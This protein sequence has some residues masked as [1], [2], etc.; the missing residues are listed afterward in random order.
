MEDKYINEVTDGVF[1]ALFFA[2]KELETISDEKNSLQIDILSA[3][4]DLEVINSLIKSKKSYIES[5]ESE[6][7]QVEDKNNKDILFVESEKLKLTNFIEEKN[8]TILQFNKAL[9]DRIA[10]VKHLDI[11]IARLS[12]VKKVLD[13]EIANSEKA[14]EKVLVN[15]DQDAISKS[16]EIEKLNSEIF[17]LSE[18]KVSLQKEIEVQKST[19]LPKL[20]EVE[21]REKKVALRE[22]TVKII[23]KRY[24][25]LFG[26]KGI[27]VNL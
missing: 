17:K 13:K 22:N 3:L 7:K 21:D 23:E 15:I 2:K 19:V 26:D 4:K 14:L 9:E 6:L 1:N 8:K 20:N 27:S 24:I 10:S 25:N 18:E 11:E 5:K 16:K 12:D